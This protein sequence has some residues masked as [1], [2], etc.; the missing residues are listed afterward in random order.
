MLVDRGQISSV[1]NSPVTLSQ[2]K[3]ERS[4]QAEVL[5]MHRTLSPISKR[6]KKVGSG[7]VQIQNL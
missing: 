7:W 6:K 1:Q 5:Q 3:F 4:L 2:G